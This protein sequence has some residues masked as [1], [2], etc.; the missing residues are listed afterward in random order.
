MPIAVKEQR[1]GDDVAPKFI[2]ERCAACT[3]LKFGTT[4]KEKTSNIMLSDSL[5]TRL[6]F[7]HN[8]I[9]E[10]I[11]ACR[12]DRLK[13]RQDPT[14]WSAFEQVV[15]L[16]AYQPTFRRRLDEILKTSSPVFERYT[17][18]NDPLFHEYLLKPLN[19]LLSILSEDRSAI[20]DLILS[21]TDEQLE[22]TGRHQ[23]YG[24][25]T[26]TGW[27]EFFLLHE[28]HHLFAIF[29]LTKT[30]HTMSQQ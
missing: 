20:N 13:T 6:K 22:L 11:S 18:D 1:F 28:A 10:L 16:V 25:L 2:S 9:S 7:Q 5:V 4:S 27:T 21:L 19:E 14:K 8:T 30:V 15:H 23:K 17:A 29:M 3:E 24:L 26:V 12:E